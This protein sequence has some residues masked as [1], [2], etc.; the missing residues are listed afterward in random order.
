[1]RRVKLLPTLVTALLFCSASVS[2]ATGDTQFQFVGDTQF[3]GFCKAVV[4]DDVGV[5][6]T[7]LTR[8]VGLI[9][10]TERE[11]LR[12]L[13]ADN[14]MTCNGASLIEFSLER[15]A[16]AVYQYLSSRS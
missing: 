3:S 10:A 8:S 13:T 16:S 7:S 6:R 12:L 2:A 15:K 5:L 14:G 9:G 11:V 1:M 4:L